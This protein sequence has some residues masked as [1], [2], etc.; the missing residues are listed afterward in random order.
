MLLWFCFFPH[1]SGI[2][3]SMCTASICYFVD[4]PNL[5]NDPFTIFVD[6]IHKERQGF[7]V[8]LLDCWSTSCLEVGMMYNYQP[9]LLKNSLR[10]PPWSKQIRWVTSSSHC[11]VV[12]SP[13]LISDVGFPGCTL[14]GHIQ[15]FP[16]FFQNSWSHLWIHH[17]CLFVSVASLALVAGQWHALFWRISWTWFIFSRRHRNRWWGCWQAT[18]PKLIRP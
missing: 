3:A 5:T 11:F 18:L 6:G 10:F 7:S 12:I 2:G 1:L 13:A 9:S 15:L 8:G 4:S 17:H 14:E 16:Q